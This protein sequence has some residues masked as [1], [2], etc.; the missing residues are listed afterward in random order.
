MM[1][2]LGRFPFSILAFIVL[3]AVAVVLIYI[4][5]AVTLPADRHVGD[6]HPAL[7]SAFSFEL[8]SAPLKMH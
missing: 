4:I 7:E 2:P 6:A 1:W 5:W 8:A 3:G